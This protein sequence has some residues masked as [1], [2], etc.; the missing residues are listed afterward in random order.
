MGF[1][2]GEAHGLPL[3]TWTLTSRMIMPLGSSAVQN[4]RRVLRSKGFQSETMIS[5]TCAPILDGLGWRHVFEHA[6]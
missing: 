1:D 6:V 5:A 4:P 3:D 2:G